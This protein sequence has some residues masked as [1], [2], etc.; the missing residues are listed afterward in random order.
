MP[1]KK[2]RKAEAVEFDLTPMIDVTFQLLIFFIVVMKFKQIEQTQAADL[3]TDSGFAMPTDAPQ[4]AIITLRLKWQNEIMVYDVCVDT[5][6]SGR[7]QINA[8]TLTQLMQGR[9]ARDGYKRS[10]DELVAG[11]HKV[12]NL[13]GKQAKKLEISYNEHNTGATS[14]EAP[15]L[16]APWGFV[17]L[18]MDAATQVNMDIEEQTGDPEKKLSVV[19]KYTQPQ[20][21]VKVAGS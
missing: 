13:M 16:T 12:Y 18:A 15:E 7:A 17:T 19:F 9:D 8:G 11:I 4:E 14:L 3:P 20:G 5:A 21:N 6:A 1:R 2:P 10:F